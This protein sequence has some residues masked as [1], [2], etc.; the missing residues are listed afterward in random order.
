VKLKGR[1]CVVAGAGRGIGAEVAHALA[2]EGARLVLAA[3]TTS[4]L[5]GVVRETMALGVD[6]CAVPADV[7]SALEASRVVRTALD[8]FGRIDVLIDAAGILGPIG[9]F[10]DTDLEEWKHAIEVN[11]YGFVHLCHAALPHMMA[12]GGGSIVAFSGGGATAPLPRFSA[13]GSSK[14]AVVRFVETAAE[15]LRSTGIRVNAIAPGLVDTRLQDGILAA[16]EYAGDQFD[17]VRRLRERGEDAV[18]PSLAAQLAV[19]LA[20]DESAGLTG[21]LISAPH[22]GW[23]SWDADRLAA[24]MQKPWYTLR[25]VDPFTLQQLQ[26]T[27]SRA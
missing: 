9:P 11:L 10:W 15:E 14:T 2:R 27:G 19:F 3:R 4:E 1:S 18:D 21:R 25:R 20:S 26:D 7:S 22:D 12:A 13:Y 6:A 5:D 24:I 16:G 8:R 17:K 23:S